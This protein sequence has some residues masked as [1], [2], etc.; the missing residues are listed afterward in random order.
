MK[1][2]FDLKTQNKDLDSANQGLTNYKYQEIQSLRSVTGGNFQEGEI[3]YRWAYGANKYW[4]PEKSYFK[5]RL[6]IS[7]VLGDHL[8]QDNNLTLS[9]NPAATLFQNISYKCADQT[10]CTITENLPQIDTLKN[11]MSKSG[12]WLNK[13]G[14]NLS[15]MIASFKERQKKIANIGGAETNG[16]IL[17]HVN[18]RDIA[19]QSNIDGQDTVQI[20][21]NGDKTYDFAFNDADA[22]SNMDLRFN[23]SIA[24]GDILTWDY[25]IV[26]LGADANNFTSRVQ[27]SG[28]ITNITQYNITVL[29]SN[30]PPV[31]MPGARQLDSGDFNFSLFVTHREL[32]DEPNAS[33]AKNIEIMWTPMLPIFNVK[34]AMPCAGTKQEITLLPYIDTQWQKNVI[35]SIYTNKQL[36]IDYT[37]TI[38][39]LRLYILTCDSNKIPETFDFML[40]FNEVQCQSSPITSTNIQQSFD[41]IPSTNAITLAI[42]DEDVI[43]NSQYSLTKFRV[44]EDI[45][46]NLTRYYIRYEGQVPTPDFEGSFDIITGTDNLIDIYN[47]TKKYDGSYY[48]ESPETLEEWRNRGMYIHHPFPKTA[49]SRNTRVYVNL[50]FS[51]LTDSAANNLNP[52]LL[53]FTHSK[54]VVIIKVVNG[55]IVSVSPYDA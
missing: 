2:I 40:D 16:G 18:F 4:I 15:W 17:H 30:Y 29:A 13:T 51:S 25:E 45:E 9:M 23:A 22:K 49:S 52:H 43:T 38:T 54:K 1:S 50:N 44:R 34:H 5:I 37:V 31:V 26:V 7:T 33:N 14:Q 3:V 42:Q 19:T 12:S 55:K 48:F 32:G 21:D 28:I 53:L 10:V 6:T 39:D 11:R 20:I 46:Q 27:G 8:V 36:G 41:V 24:I 47:R 35:E